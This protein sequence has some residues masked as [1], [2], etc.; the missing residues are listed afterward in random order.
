MVSGGNREHRT[1]SR[2]LNPENVPFSISDILLLLIV[3]VIVHLGSVFGA[4]PMQA[5]GCCTHLCRW[6]P[7]LCWYPG[8]DHHICSQGA[9]LF[10]PQVGQVTSAAAAGQWAATWRSRPFHF[11]C[12]CSNAML[13]YHCHHISS[14]TSLHYH[15]VLPS[16]VTIFFFSKC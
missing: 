5:S 1:L 10:F 8:C 7:Q 4:G 16:F 14:S 3:R 11:L 9:M 6:C 15:S 2:R 12:S 13:P